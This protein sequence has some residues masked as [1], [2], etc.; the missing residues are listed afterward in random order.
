VCRRWRDKVT[1]SARL[2]NARAMI[3]VNR[4]VGWNF[5]QTQ[6]DDRLT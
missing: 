3:A 6:L 4:A 5:R 2:E 1:K